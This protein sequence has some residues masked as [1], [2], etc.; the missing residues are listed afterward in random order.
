MQ[1]SRRWRTEFHR[2]TNSKVIYLIGDIQSETILQ[3]TT[4]INW[5]LISSML[6]PDKLM[7]CHCP[8]IYSHLIKLFRSLTISINTI[9]EWDFL[10]QLCTSF[11]RTL[12]ATALPYCFRTC[13]NTDLLGEADR[14]RALRWVN[15]HS[16]SRLILNYGKIIFSYVWQSV[17]SGFE[18]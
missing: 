9:I 17:W 8:L 12:Q 4:F 16:C 13:F 6:R 2:I 10:L 18:W 15:R 3:R 5:L 11:F 7:I 14:N 1:Y